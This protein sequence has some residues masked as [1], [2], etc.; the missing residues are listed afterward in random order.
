MLLNSMSLFV[1][2]KAFYQLWRE[3]ASYFLWVWD[4]VLIVL[5]ALEKL[6]HFLLASMVY[7]EKSTV[8]LILFPL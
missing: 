5:S 6:Y 7:Q 4:S 3:K 8:I 2:V 1:F